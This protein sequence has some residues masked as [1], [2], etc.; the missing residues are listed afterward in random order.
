M[1]STGQSR[2]L[3][4]QASPIL[5]CVH[6]V[7]A[8]CRIDRNPPTADR[9]R[10]HFPH[11]DEVVVHFGCRLRHG[12]QRVPGELATAVDFARARRQRRPIV[13]GHDGAG[14]PLLS[15]T[16]EIRVQRRCESRDQGCGDRC[17][18]RSEHVGATESAGCIADPWPA[19]ML[20]TGHHVA[21]EFAERHR[22]RGL[23]CTVDRVWITRLDQLKQTKIR[24]ATGLQRLQERHTRRR[25]QHLVDQIW[26]H[27]HLP[28]FAPST[29]LAGR[30][31]QPANTNTQPPDTART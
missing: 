4:D 23:R 19:D 21:Y 25:R 28:I 8:S 27:W 12:P 5:G 20:R 18:C 13:V 3:H 11:V 2:V 9:S 29:R 10:E 6:L 24:T 1:R 15:P 17:P 16:G 7:D 31:S 26:L 14:P 30:G 22:R